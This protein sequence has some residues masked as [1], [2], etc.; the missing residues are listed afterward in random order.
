[1]NTIVEVKNGGAEISLKDALLYIL[2]CRQH[3]GPRSFGGALKFGACIAQ[4]RREGLAD[5]LSEYEKNFSVGLSSP[6]RG[7]EKLVFA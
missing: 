7:E 2:E 5:L 4:V 6:L 1:M 3:N